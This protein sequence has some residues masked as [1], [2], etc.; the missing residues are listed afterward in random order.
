MWSRLSCGFAL[1]VLSVISGC[2]PI[3]TDPDAAGS[4]GF[5]ELSYFNESWGFQI[6]RPNDLWGI[7]VQTFE[8]DRD[9][10]GLPFVDVRIASP[11]SALVGGFRPQMRLFPRALPE[12]TTLDELAQSYEEQDLIPQ[13]DRYRVV[14]D[15]VRVQLDGGEAIQWQFRYSQLE[16]SNRFHPGSRFIVAVAVHNQVGY[17]MIGN[18]GQDAGYPLEEYQQIVSSLHWPIIANDQ[19]VS[20]ASTGF[21]RVPPPGRTY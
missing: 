14:G 20:L 5:S 21:F 1:C 19:A 12:G 18:G 8:L 2:S 15:K 13:F 17:F 16:A 7:T 6:S 3:P 4:S 11:V 10:N 9:T